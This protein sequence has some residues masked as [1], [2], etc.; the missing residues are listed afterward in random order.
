M[1]NRFGDSLSLEQLAE[2]L[3]AYIPATLTHQILTD[4]LPPPGKPRSLM[5]ATLFSDISG[6]TAMSEELATDGPRGAEELNRV[7]LVTFTAMIDVIREMGGAVAHFYGDAMSVYFPD[8]DGQAAYRALACAQMMQ[9]LMLSSF[10]RVVTNRPQGKRP[11]F[12]LTIKI[13]AGYGHCQEMVLS[14]PGQ[15][16]EFVLMG[17][18][19]D[20][21]AAAE[22]TAGS[23]E[24]M[25]SSAI[26]RQ[27]DLPAGS[28][29]GPISARLDQPALTRPI[30]QWNRFS[31][32][33]LQRL[34]SAAPA[35]IP[36]ALY[37]RLAAGSGE[38]LAEH[39]PVSSIF[40]QFAFADEPVSDA[41][42]QGV[43]LQEYFQWASGLV[44]RF[45]ETNARVNRVLTGDKGNQLH[46]I[47]G[48]PVAPDAPEQALR[49][50][51]ALQR[52]RPSFVAQQY[53]GVA[54]G[55]VFAGPVGSHSRREY[56]VVGDVVNLSARLMQ[57]CAANEVWTNRLTADRAH[58]WIEFEALPA[59]T[60][61]GKQ[62][63]VTP[64]RVVGERL[65]TTQLQAY[66]DR[67]KRPMFGR[68]HEIH[69]LNQG[70]EKALS[71]ESSV[72]A[73]FGPTGAG[74]SRLLA[75]LAR[76]WLER[77]GIGLLGV[78]QQHTAD[79]PYAPWRAIM[80]DFFGLSATMSIDAQVASVT[81][82]TE[83]LAPSQ[84]Q[85][86]GLWGD[87]L[88]LP[89]PESESVLNLTAEARQ[90][91]FFTLVRR[92]FQA[93]ARRQP[94][95]VILDSLHWADP[96]S[97]SLLDDLTANLEQASIFVAFTFRPL[98]ELKLATL[99]RS[100][101]L[102]IPV[103]DLSPVHARRLLRH[104]TGQDELPTEVEIHLGLRDRDGRDS[105][106]NPLFLEEAL[107][108]M[109]STGVLERNGRIRVNEAL[110]DQV[111][112]PDT[113][114]GLLL[115]RLDRL[116]P[117]A[118]DLLQVASVIGRQFE[119][120]PL[121][122]IAQRLPRSMML[123]MLAEL[124][125]ADMTQLVASDPEWVYL[126]QHA[127]THEVAYESLP[128]ARRQTLHAAV[129]EWVERRN[130][131][132][133]RPFHPVLAFHYSRAAAHEPALR[134]SLLAAKDAQAIFANKEAV[135]LYNLAEKHLQALGV[136]AH[137]ESAVDL[138][139][140]RAEALLLLGDFG[141]A[142]EDGNVGKTLSWQH[143]DVLRFVKALNLLSELKYRQSKFDEAISFAQ[144]VV[145]KWA[146]AAPQTELARAY[147]WLGMAA[148][149]TRMH[150]LAQSSLKKAEEITLKLK[151]DKRLARVLEGMAFNSFMQKDLESALSAMQRSVAL[152]R[153]F[154]NPANTAS[155]LNNIALIQFQ[156][157]NP[158]Q[159][160][161]TIGE[162]IDIGKESS[163]NFLA[164]ALSNQGEVLSYLGRYAEANAAFEKAIALFTAMDD[165]PGI[166]ETHLLWGYEYCA[167]LNLWDEARLHYTAAQEI[168]GTNPSVYLEEQARLLIAAGQLE[169]AE[170]NLLL[171][172]EL[173]HDALEIV[174]T[175]AIEWWMPA[176]TYFLARTYRRLDQVETAERLLLQ[177]KSVSEQEGCPDYLP[178]ILYELA[179]IAQ[180]PRHKEEHLKQCLTAAQTRARFADRRFLFEKA[181][182]ELAATTRRAELKQMGRFFINEARTLK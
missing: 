164:Q 96:S 116:P 157:G 79:I 145:E 77:G 99:E 58:Q 20:E 48:A 179:Q 108:V 26:R 82:Q 90:A 103:S 168:L 71:G 60:L 148:S 113:I 102:P 180:N 120:E 11:F 57:A 109:M 98:E 138:R 100:F 121:S 144:E 4:G 123:E 64:F 83:A 131:E 160:L 107:N 149:S 24:I 2:T 18:A 76:A 92:C 182:S 159:S 127:M 178:L 170:S 49:C 1:E 44:T 23:G 135:D 12:D 80:R 21:A 140:S 67:W 169:L 6:F 139:L 41:S 55:K 22:K 72:A 13:G 132:N 141:T 181:G 175:N 104:L 9:Q 101:C 14:T 147:H 8:D 166:L 75:F 88:G 130:V 167:P 25:A 89:I 65:A 56:T 34:V 69:L 47:F 151:D 94:L 125:E 61:K 146:D 91:R 52:E 38:A 45:G 150:D 84:Q 153:D 136:E 142:V 16:M 87:L 161:E 143:Q 33:D 137:W 119:L 156:L 73:V 93:A 70:L 165:D 68:D 7:L 162:A 152:S 173:L 30:V 78:C 124:T 95:L 134:Y 114:H 63:A 62:T 133:L 118:R 3:S 31:K 15:G 154:N 5:A 81:A 43:L 50:A 105:P 106:V 86:V 74:K 27:A 46:I 112:L 28:A 10:G 97:L 155:S 177:G 110:L 35:F 59:V 174:D 53:I 51:L 32:D 85:D 66:L 115:A 129:A 39:R 122:A 111:Q 171:A 158:Q 163:R 19:V 128:Y 176:C 29:F 172:Q 17:T 42:T 54:V 40:V 126:F 36:P 37:Q 117:S